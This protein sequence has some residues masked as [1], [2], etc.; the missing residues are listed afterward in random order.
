ML[1]SFK[2]SFIS[3]ALFVAYAGAFTHLHKGPQHHGEDF[4]LR[5]FT[6]G[7]ATSSAL[8]EESEFLTDSDH[9]ISFAVDLKMDSVLWEE[10]EDDGIEMLS[11]LSR[12]NAHEVMVHLSGP[13]LDMEDYEPGSA[14]VIAAER[15]ETLCGP[16]RS[17]DGIIRDDPILFFRMDNVTALESSQKIGLNM[18]A[19]PGSLV[20]PS[21][22]F[23]ILERPLKHHTKRRYLFHDS[24]LYGAASRMLGAPIGSLSDAESRGGSEVFSEFALFPG[25][26]LSVSGT[27]EGSIRNVRITRLSK[28]EV[29]WEQA[30]KSNISSRLIAS[31]MYLAS[32]EKEVHRKPIKGATT[33]GEIAFFGR[34]SVNAATTVDLVQEVGADAG[35][36]AFLSAS[37]ENLQAVTAS[38]ASKNVDADSLLPPDAGSYGTFDINFDHVIDQRAGINGFY[39]ARPGIVVEV[40]FAGFSFRG[41]YTATLGLEASMEIR[42]PPFQPVPHGAKISG[43]C[44]ECH[45]LQGRAS[46]KG[47]DL[48]YRIYENG[49]LQ[50]HKVLDRNLFEKEITTICAFAQVCPV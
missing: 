2:L 9:T 33:S 18:R 24:P 36:N 27:I 31:R 6:H 45:R 13:K 10:L 23:D 43:N 26:N 46:V 44:K 39:G 16:I 49:V 48:Q 30:L 47:K 35:V 11:C 8:P 20:A 1:S 21:F 3:I 32:N 42:Q 15:W 4:V 12:E 37:H 40:Q 41:T 38:F 19:I 34:Y 25:A 22:S 28:L 5:G 29:A 14:F 17:L 7:S 50:K